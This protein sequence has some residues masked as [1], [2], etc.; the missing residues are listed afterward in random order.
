MSK[1]K[2]NAIAFFPQLSKQTWPRGPHRCAEGLVEGNSVRRK[3]KKVKTCQ[4]F[5]SVLMFFCWNWDELG[6]QGDRD[7]RQNLLE[8]LLIL[9][10][11]HGSSSHILLQ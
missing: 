4:D 6:Q 1:R 7:P 3:S 10:D 5:L 9:K 11:F 2:I 8:A